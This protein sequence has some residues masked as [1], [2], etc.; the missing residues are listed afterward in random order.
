MEING[1]NGR[2]KTKLTTNKVARFFD[3]QGFYIVLF[4]C[5]AA[6]GLTAY[7]AFQGGDTNNTNDNN[8]A[9]VQNIP[10][11]GLQEQ[12]A[13]LSPRISVYPSPTIKPQPTQAAEAPDSSISSPASVQNMVKLGMPVEGELLMA[14]ADQSL[15]YSITLNQW[16][17]HSGID[18]SADEG[19]D[20]KAALDGTIQSVKSDTMMGFTVVIKHENDQTT[21]YANLAETTLVKEGDK[22]TKGQVIGKVGKTAIAECMEVPHLHFEYMVKGKNVDPAKYISGLVSDETMAQGK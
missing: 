6:I 1:K 22:V 19:A 18:I 3:K 5:L 17:T 2:R 11:G 10:N 4:L 20:V 9:Q 21:T 12:L 7:F 16:S 14:F 13:Q 15:L 8:E